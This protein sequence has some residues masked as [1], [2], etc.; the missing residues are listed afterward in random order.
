MPEYLEIAVN[1]PHV[2]EVFH[3]HLPAR[4]EGRVG[5]GHLVEVP[6]GRQRVQGLVL[7]PVAEPAVPETR[8]VHALLDPQPVLTAA[9]LDLAR[10]L[11]R[12]TLASLA[13]CINLM[14]PPGLNQL[15][16]TRYALALEGPPAKGLTDLQAQL[17]KLLKRRGPLRGR[18]IDRALP[19]LRWRRSAQS[20]VRRGILQSESVLSPPTVKP[21]VVR[22][23]Q[24]ASPPAEARAA[25]EGLGRAGSKALARRQAILRF[26]IEEPEEVDVAWVYAK[27][28]GSLQDLRHLA[29]R[30]L[31]RLGESQI[32]RDPLAGLEPVPAEPPT[33]T[34]D[35][36][37][38]WDAVRSGIDASIA[39]EAVMPFLLHGVTGSGK[40][41]IYLRAVAEVLRR[42]RGAIILVPEIALTPQTVRRFVARFPGQVG[43]VHSRLSVGE[44]YD[45]W[46]RARA[47]QLNVVIGPRSALFT[48][49]PHLGLI[50][51]D[52]AH[53]DSY[54]QNEP[55]PAY[56]AREA[57]VAYAR[58]AGAVCLCGSATPDVVTTYRADQGAW[59]RLRLPARI[60]AHRDVL[61]AQQER[62]KGPSRY[63][64]AGGQAESVD[65]PPVSVIDMREELKAGNRSIFSRSLQEALHAVLARG[66]Q[67]ILFLNRRGTATYVFCRDCGYALRC[68]RCDTSLTYH[69]PQEKLTCHHCGYRRNLPPKCPQCGSDRI[70]GYGTGTEKVE[71]EVQKLLDGARTLRW[72]WETTRQK[73]AHDL[74]L[75]H[76]SG[77]KAD[78]LIGTQMLA[79]GLD[80][81]L[82]TLVGV[83]LADVGLNLPDYRAAERTFQVLAQVSGRAGR[84]PLG[85][86]V[87]LQT[88]Q[89]EHYV[90]RAASRHDYEAFY[91]EELGLRRNVGY[92]PFA[93]LLRLE[94]RHH[95]AERAE[96]Q[97]RALAG[98]LGRWL[99]EEGRRATE[100]VGPTPCFYARLDGQYR[101]QILLRGPDPAS[102][103]LGRTLPEWRVT[104]N[105]PSL[106]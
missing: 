31:V 82:V 63:R 49:L 101:W 4:L 64:P 67:A 3:Y 93:R 15:A 26:L 105:P 95:Q 27:S 66:E 12:Q 98:Q 46:R 8:P 74:I 14:V 25:L 16:D 24:L 1:V 23:V 96:R 92:P 88:F 30:G 75:R 77:H 69:R 39:G 17:V 59:M 79:K 62:I 87:I 42:G 7:Q 54:F 58:L 10:E 41:E 53:D 84:S 102:V 13:S 20:L 37:S 32:W 11:S 85:G 45:T 90:I 44:R 83:I 51:V 2:T 36:R 21:K 50:V 99:V 106:L 104:V 6:F 40:T 61:Q 72:D 97:A 76:F 9:Q 94:Y 91:R 57:A 18:Q 35:Q 70:R 73:G 86:Q 19:R 68:P 33:L 103:L 71:S 80:L 56:H 34:A 48:P 78:V 5:P 100:L 22:T 47:G 52:E 55:P 60:L 65:L 89:P 43:L 29:E 81:P 38:A 28:G